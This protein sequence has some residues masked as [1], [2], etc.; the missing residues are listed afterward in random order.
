MNISLSKRFAIGFIALLLSLGGAVESVAAEYPEFN[1]DIYVHVGTSTYAQSSYI[2]MYDV[3]PATNGV[4]NG[5]FV[6]VKKQTNG[7]APSFKITAGRIVDFVAFS[8]RTTALRATRWTFTTPPYKNFDANGI[9]Q[10][11]YLDKYTKLISNGYS[12][13]C[14][15]GISKPLSDSYIAF[16]NFTRTKSRTSLSSVEAWPMASNDPTSIVEG[17]NVYLYDEYGNVIAPS[18]NTGTR[19]IATFI[20]ERGKRFYVQAEKNGKYYGGRTKVYYPN[21]TAIF[22][23][24]QDGKTL[25]DT[26]NGSSTYETKLNLYP[27]SGI[28]VDPDPVTPYLS[29]P[30][31]TNPI[32]NALLTGTYPQTVYLTWTPISGASNYEIDL[33]MSSCGNSCSSQWY[34][35]QQNVTTNTP[36]YTTRTLTSN[37]YYRVR[38]RALDTTGVRSSWSSYVTFSYNSSPVTP[39]HIGISTP[40]ITYPANYSEIN[41]DRANSKSVLVTWNQVSGASRYEIYTESA[42][43]SC[44]NYNG[45]SNGYTATSYVNST[46]IQTS[47]NYQYRSRVRAIDYE[48]QTSSWSDYRYFGSYTTNQNQ[49]LS[50]PVIYSPSSDAILSSS[51][52]KVFMSWGAVAGASSYKYELFLVRYVNGQAT[53]TSYGTTPAYGT[54]ATSYPLSDNSN[55]AVR[56]RAVQNGVEGVWSG[57]R[58]FSLRSVQY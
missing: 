22:Y 46:V 4:Y 23:I 25:V 26:Y 15:T 43:I 41:A 19:G 6:S 12:Q 48:G 32:N 8:D 1:Y 38:V 30:T 7:V 37:F 42:C 3:T 29:T 58:Y 57:Y 35:F 52:A 10:I 51:D 54:S 45:W 18:V 36:V 33:D 2:A 53:F 5:K 31:V 47:L 28:V 27:S 16:Q 44:S 39:V 13:S 20:V 24:S 21:Q 55:Y 34:D 49:V 9:C 11:N 17:A 40:V 50:A 14:T 56:V